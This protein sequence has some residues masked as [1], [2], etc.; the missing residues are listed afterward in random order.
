MEGYDHSE[1]DPDLQDNDEDGE[2][3]EQEGTSYF[4]WQILDRNL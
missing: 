3:S 4:F 1:N 2:L